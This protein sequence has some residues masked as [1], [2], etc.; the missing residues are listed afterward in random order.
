[1][2]YIFNNFGLMFYS[3]L[4]FYDIQVIDY[5]ILKCLIII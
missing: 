4:Y 1:M 5:N 3:N 2:N